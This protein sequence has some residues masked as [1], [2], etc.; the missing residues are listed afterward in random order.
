METDEQLLQLNRLY[1]TL[2]QVNQAIMHVCDNSVL[3]HE[4]CKIAVQYGQFR[5]AWVGLINEKDNRVK[6]VAFA[7]E[8]QGYLDKVNIVVSGNERSKGP[9]GEAIHEGHLVFCQDIATDPRMIPW[10]EDA[11]SRG[12]RSSAAIPIRK[13]GVVIGA[14]TV[15]APEP[16]IFDQKEVQLLEE[17]GTNLSFGLDLIE[18]ED[19]RYQANKALKESELRYRST[20]DSMLEGCQIIGFDWRYIYLNHTADKH[21]RRPKEE[22]LG[23]KYMDM[24]PGIEETEV[25]RMIKHCMDQRIPHHMENEFAFPDGKLGWFDLSIQPVPEG[26]FIL[27]VDITDRKQTEIALKE[28]EQKFRET[29][30]NLD[31]GYYSV[32]MEGELLEHNRAFNL[33][34]GFGKMVDL[35]GSKLPDFWLEPEKRN[36]YL[37]MLLTNGFISNYQIEGKTITGEI[38]TVLANAHMVYNQNKQPIRIEGMLLDITDRK[39]AEE[40]LQISEENF[41][42]IFEYSVVGKAITT[43]D[44]KMKV[45]LSYRNILGYSEEELLHLTWKEITHPDDIERDMKIM[46]SVISGEKETIRWEK[47]YIHKNGNTVWVDISTTLHR[48]GKGIAHYFI[49]SIIDI[50][51]RKHAEAELRLQSEIMSHIAEAV[52]LV[53]MDDGMIVYA[54]PQFEEL[55]GYNRDE[56]LGLHVSVVNAPGSK[57][58]EETVSEIMDSLQKKGFWKEEVHNIKKDGTTFWCYASVTLFDHSLFGKVLVA[59]HM[60][61]TER[62]LAEEKIRESDLLQRELIKHLPHQVFIKDIHSNYLTCNTNYA[63]DLGI[64]VDEI[65]GK[66]DFDFFPEVLAKAYQT[67]DREVMQ[68]GVIKNIEEKI[69]IHGRERDIHTIKVPFRINEEKIFGIL[70]VYEDITE[71]KRNEQTLRRYTERLKNLHQIDQAILQAVESPEKIV[72]VALRHISHL[73]N[74]QQARIGLLDPAKKSVKL[75]ASKTSSPKMDPLRTKQLEENFFNLSVLRQKKP[76]VVE[77]LELVESPSAAQKILISEGIKSYMNVPLLSENRLIGVLNLGWSNSRTFETEEIEIAHEV[78]GQI[79]L[80]MEQARFRQEIQQYAAE[81]EQRVAERTRELQDLY[82]KAPCG[83]HSLDS[84][85]NIV[86]INDT[87]LE[88]MGYK[89]EEMEN[90]VNIMEILTEE[91][92]QTFRENFPVYMKTGVLTNLEM[93][94]IRK[95]GSILSVL[96]NA[97]AIFDSD[98]HFV[99]SRST[100][101]DHTDRKKAER[102]LNMA[103]KKLEESNKELEAFSYSV[104]HDLR[105]PLRHISGFVDMLMDE[106]RDSLSG[107]AVHYLDIITGSAYQMGVLIDDL[108]QFSRTGRQ[109]MRQADVDMKALVH[110]VVGVLCEDRE[111]MDRNINWIISDLPKVYGDNSLLKQV[112]VNLIG[113]ALK[114]TR[115]K[116]KA[117][118]EIGCEHFNHE[119][120]FFVRD[121]GAGFDMRY[122]NKL[123]GV[124][125]RLHASAEFEG[126]GIGL[127][128]VRRIVLKH[129]GLTWAE[130][131]INKGAVFYFTLPKR[132]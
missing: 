83:Y 16:L 14:L 51:E 50:T 18:R 63:R 36:D 95:D 60:D 27:S 34:L 13:S 76:V 68:K 75:F 77:N 114:F 94:F 124:F 103:L 21:N 64:T 96:L 1:A 32:T 104:S 46:E 48:D 70:G 38:K 42:N 69:V 15:Y 31:E 28:S 44:G 81:L 78:A 47:R 12:F 49:T 118:I 127:A 19:Q 97:T 40:A 30:I 65:T 107:K 6:P 55:F 56:L 2:S 87:E 74:C 85:G 41:R 92:R 17:I 62:R 23:H 73:L 66:D 33:I 43:L 86:L 20:L 67:D 4:V 25:F 106:T 101:T 29:L 93:D 57:K 122:A 71:R 123:F 111:V 11:L 35:R 3:Y 126:T 84:K 89:R 120:R 100:I 98:G 5:L 90:K 79:T 121:N 9:T 45:N 108:L 131:E 52:Y 54:N 130:S 129:D 61:I 105:A 80:A 125:Q 39:K 59:V 102:A 115:K 26:V 22:L 88:W 119:Y 109:E 117:M 37:K 113:N 116:E 10:R 91:S 132:D 128:N 8:E 7:G 53:R 110:E 82:N 99:R 72:R 112:W 58:P 24:W